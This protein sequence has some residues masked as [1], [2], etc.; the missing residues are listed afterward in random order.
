MLNKKGFT[1]AEVIISFSLLSVILASVIG[2]TVFY[3]DKLKEEE[4]VTQLM[5]FKNT[6]TKTIYDDIL[7]YQSRKLIK[8]E[9]C[10][11]TANCINFLDKNDDS[12]V[13]K[14]VEYTE[15]NNEHK[16]G[17]Y[18]SYDN[19]LYMLPDS[20]LGSAESRVCDFIGGFNID[21]YKENGLEI[22]TVKT[23]FKHKDLNK[24][25]DIMLT[26]THDDKN[27]QS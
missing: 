26:I 27:N 11:G 19:T 5:D 20:D 12:H 3:R 4:V 18:L 8:A 1:I 21:Y 15:S 9:T 17:V 24:E 6:I 13:L 23:K 7:T 16:K 10:I 22:Y 25:Y 2:S 14:I